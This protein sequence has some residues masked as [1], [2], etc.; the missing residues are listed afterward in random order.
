MG[1]EHLNAIGK[2]IVVKQ[3][4]VGICWGCHNDSQKTP[5]T[6]YRHQ[7][8]NL[9]MTFHQSTTIKKN[10][11]EQRDVRN[12]TS[13]GGAWESLHIGEPELRTK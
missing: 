5:P 10:R 8:T 4:I 1:D 7:P 9:Q 12:P 13:G 6:L 3:E 2:D 11:F